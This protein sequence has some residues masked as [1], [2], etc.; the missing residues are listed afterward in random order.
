V[1]G[2][3][4]PTCGGPVSEATGLCSSCDVLSSTKTFIAPSDPGPATDPRLSPTP[5][6]VLGSSFNPG[7]SFADRYTIVERIGD[8]GMGEVYKAIDRR[9][10]GHTVALKLIRAS[11]A[12]RGDAL[13]RFRREL[14]LAQKVS[15][16]NVCRLHDLGEVHGQLYI[17]MEYVD[18]QTLD[19]LIRTMGRLSPLQTSSLGRQICEGLRAVHEQGIIHRDLKPSNVMVDRAGHA[20]VMDFGMAY[21]PEAEKLTRAG[22]V[23]GTLAYVAPE[24]AR[25]V[26]TDARSDVYAL[27]L[28]LYEMLTGRRPPGDGAP[29]PLALRDAAE[30]CPPPSHFAPEVHPVLD[31]VVMRCLYRDP[32]AR[33]PTMAEVGEALARASDALATTLAPATAPPT[34]VAAVTAVPKPGAD[35]LRLLSALLGA[36]LVG[37]LLFRLAERPPRP[38]VSIAVCPLTFVGNREHANLASLVPLFLSDELRTRKGCAV[39]PFA[40]ARTFAPN[41]DPGAVARELLVGFV[42]QGEIRVEGRR[43]HTVLRLRRIGAPETESRTFDSEAENVLTAG[44]AMV[45]WISSAAGIPPATGGVSANRLAAME[46]YLQGRTYLE[47]WD[48]ASNCARAA[49]AFRAAI[50]RDPTFA[51]AHARLALALFKDYEDTRIPERVP[52][53]EGAAERA[54]ALA[55]DLPEAQLAQGVIQLGRGSSAEAAATLKRARDLAPADDVIVRRIAEAYAESHRKKEAE[56]LFRRAISLRPSYWE[57]YNALGRFLVNVGRFEDA[58]PLYREVIRLRP[59]SDV[60]YTNLAGVHLYRGE[61]EEAEPLLK[62]SLLKRPMAQAHNFLGFV[63]YATGRFEEAARQFEAAAETGAEHLAYR[64]NLGDA[65]RQLGRRAEANAAYADAIAMG[66]RQLAVNPRDA[67]T[68]AGLSMFLAASG[69]CREA[70]AGVNAALREDPENP[71]VHYYAAVSYALCGKRAAA[72]DETVRAIQGGMLVDVSTNPDLRSLLSEPSVKGAL[73][74]ARSAS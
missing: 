51:E 64:G 59:E 13:E 25:G 63:Y 31:G 49:E 50:A 44:P 54:V 12:R 15:H 62:T 4:C 33:F 48:V 56:D 60:G 11:L 27:G 22:M 23:V 19:D 42:V 6:P 68:R 28:L 47:G 58:K 45:E 1:T 2:T 29:L 39:A 17:S 43:A 57:N 36:V 46:P 8:G 5:D 24:Q 34:A 74:R 3:S 35:R 67:T 41:A 30:A 71:S 10:L 16:P 38:P 21:H 52:E 20:I 53:A 72:V 14:D 61:L 65:Y 32:G 9:R 73:D 37:A 66:E 69:R 70:P 55:P 26:A 40:S 18:G 7:Q